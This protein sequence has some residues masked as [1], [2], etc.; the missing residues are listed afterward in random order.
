MGIEVDPVARLTLII[1]KIF[2]LVSVTHHVAFV[3][4]TLE[5]DLRKNLSSTFI[6]W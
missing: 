3:L 2:L 6:L 1:V 5:I 4:K